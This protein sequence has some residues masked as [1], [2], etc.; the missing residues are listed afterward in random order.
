MRGRFG[1]INRLTYTGY[2]SEGTGTQVARKTE[3]GAYLRQARA[4]LFL[5]W[6]L[7]HTLLERDLTPT[8]ALYSETRM[9]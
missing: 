2:L 6:Q 4:L 5:L 8:S 7:S 9:Q 1:G 3:R